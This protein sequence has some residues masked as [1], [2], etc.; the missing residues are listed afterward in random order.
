[1][2]LDAFRSQHTK[3]VDVCLSGNIQKVNF[4][5]RGDGEDS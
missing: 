5:S 4:H 2:L 3:R 1:M